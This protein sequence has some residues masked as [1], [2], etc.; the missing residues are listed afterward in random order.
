[1]SH[2]KKAMSLLLQHNKE[3]EMK[4]RSP[5]HKGWTGSDSRHELSLGVHRGTR[6]RP[7]TGMEAHW[8]RER[9]TRPPDQGKV[10]PSS[11]SQGRRGLRRAQGEGKWRVFNAWGNETR[12]KTGCGV[13]SLDTTTHTA[14][15]MVSRRTKKNYALKSTEWKS[16]C[17]GV[18]LLLM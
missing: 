2:P 11:G 16:L 7:R 17:N 8:L 12:M 4:T 14:L 15:W 13:W 1:M 6:E 3:A 5:Q 9:V 18:C 10:E